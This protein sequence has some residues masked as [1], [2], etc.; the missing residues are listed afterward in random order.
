MAP[1][2]VVNAVD[3]VIDL[4]VMASLPAVVES[5]ADDDEHGDH[6]HAADRQRGDQRGIARAQLVL[7]DGQ[8]PCA[9]L[10]RQTAV[11]P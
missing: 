5:L 11:G 3:E 10:G 7:S 2:S 9:L 6:E 1:C 4:G 8:I